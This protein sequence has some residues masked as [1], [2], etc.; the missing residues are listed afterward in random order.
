VSSPGFDLASA[1]S[2]FTVRAGSAGFTTSAF[3]TLETMVIGVRS[4]SM[5]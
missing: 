2:S 1:T 5:S 3:A 4:R